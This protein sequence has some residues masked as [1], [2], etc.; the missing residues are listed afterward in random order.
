MGRANVRNGEFKTTEPHGHPVDLELV[1]KFRFRH[2][3]QMRAAEETL[4]IAE[5][6]KQEASAMGG[7]PGLKLKS[8]NRGMY[9]ARHGELPPPPKSINELATIL[10]DDK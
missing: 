2:R 3:L 10:V 1:K 5:I 7:I 8:V 9:R 6:Y 4:S